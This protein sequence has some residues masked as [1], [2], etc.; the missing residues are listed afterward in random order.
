[1]IELTTGVVFLI[2]SLYGSGQSDSHLDNIKNDS[3]EAAVAIAA[4]ARSESVSGDSRSIEAYLREEY[5][6]EP[7]LIDIARCESNFRQFDSDGEVM[8]GKANPADVGVMQI[9]EKYQGDTAKI[10]GLDIYTIEGNVAY[11]K[12]LYEEQGTKPWSAS[13]KCWSAGS[14]IAKN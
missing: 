4:P 5:A 13:S 3:Q 6:D 7:I 12:H 14:S 8:R 10:L 1:M 2:S 9:N 11:A